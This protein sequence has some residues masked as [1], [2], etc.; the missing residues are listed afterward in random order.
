[1]L[2]KSMKNLRKSS[3]YLYE[4]VT[5]CLV[6]CVLLFFGHFNFYW[7]FDWV[8]CSNINW[9]DVA[10]F[11]R[12]FL[13]LNQYFFHVSLMFLWRPNQTSLITRWMI[14]CFK[15]LSKAIYFYV[16]FCLFRFIRSVRR[17]YPIRSFVFLIVLWHLLMPWMFF[18]MALQIEN[19]KHNKHCF[20]IRFK[21]RRIT[22]M[23]KNHI[24]THKM[25]MTPFESD[26]QRKEN[27]QLADSH[28]IIECRL[29]MR[30]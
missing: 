19:H 5:V 9:C 7:W 20:L 6:V 4:T 25:L 22:K 12:R 23:K 29:S 30:G 3:N 13:W 21:H 24:H 26:T 27:K 14:I 18:P 28:S 15:L 2:E 1:M 11:G 17:A 10:L 16:W 8:E